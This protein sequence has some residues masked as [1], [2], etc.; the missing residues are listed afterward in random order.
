MNA[1]LSWFFGAFALCATALCGMND[2][3]DQC[4]RLLQACSVVS[5]VLAGYHASRPPNPP[6]N[7]PGVPVQVLLLML[8]LLVW[9][10]GC[11]IAEFSGSVKSS[12]LGSAAFSLG[13][14]QI[15]SPGPSLRPCPCLRSNATLSAQ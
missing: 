4:R 13:G 11:R 12:T 14:G 1:K 7:P 10:P 5:S 6:N 8:L 15:G 3:S 9:G 2:L